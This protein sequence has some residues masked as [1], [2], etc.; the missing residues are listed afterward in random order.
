MTTLNATPVSDLVTVTVNGEEKKL[1]KGKN[2]L[3]ALLDDG[4]YIPHYCWHPSISVAGNC[5]LCLVEIEG[6]PR[7]NVSCNMNCSEGLKI[8]TDSPMVEDCRKGMMELL[9]VNHPLDCPVCDRGGECMLQRYSM[10]YG[11][12]TARTTDERRRF[13]KPQFDPLVDIERNRCIMC[14]RCVR[15]MDEVA[16]DHLLG[17]FGRGNRNY[18]GTFGNGPVAN[19]FS[20]NIIDIC[21]VGCL[22]S[23]PFRFQARAW[24]LQQVTSTCN[25]CSAG[26]P[27]TAWIRDG[28]LMRMTP[29]AAKYKGQWTIDE[30]TTKFICNEGRF[31]NYYANGE[32][33]LMKGL[34][35]ENGVQT[36]CEW[37]SGISHAAAALKNAATSGADKVAILTGAR[38]TNEEAYLLSRLAKSVLGTNQIDWRLDA[39]SAE[40][41]RAIGAALAS[42][43]GDIA[44][45]ETKAYGVTVVIQANLLDT[46]PVIGLKVKEA[47]R[48]KHTKLAVL[49]SRLDGWMSEQ[50]A[51]TA[52]VAPESLA[53]AVA[54][55]GG[56]GKASAE[57]EQIAS[58][59][60]GS[61]TGLIVLGM[62]GSGGANTSRIFAAVSELL[63]K[64]PEGWRFLPVIRGRNAKGAFAAGAQSDRLPSGS[65]TSDS[66]RNRM[67]EMWG[68]VAAAGED[69]PT[70]MDILERA[71]AGQIETLFL[72]RCDELVHHP[73]R[74]L[75]E[76]AL[77][78]TPNVI[79]V[80]LFPSWVTKHA[81]V[82][83]PGAAFFETEGSLTSADGTILAL[84]QAN[85]A[86]GDAQEDWRILATLM[87][88]IAG[89]KH[90]Y[91]K[92][93]DVLREVLTCWQSPRVFTINELRLDGPGVESP[94]RPQSVIRKKARPNFR[95]H[96]TERQAF[97]SASPKATKPAAG[98]LRLIYDIAVH[99]PDHL[100]TRSREFD[101]LRPEP[102]I[103]LHPDDAKR[104]KLGAGD[105]VRVSG[106]R[107]EKMKVRINESLVKGCAYGASNVLGLEIAEGDELPVIEIE[108]VGS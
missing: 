97:K 16:G 19:N 21:P 1:P 37:K 107:T 78:A 35:R 49:D 71:A 77:E 55:L 82:L 29:P 22:T 57:I 76:K 99:G 45:L 67:A 12:G 48:L 104:L 30:D 94:Q 79:V 61:P 33:R 47:A 74:A 92:L 83:L 24:E 80:D 87:E 40:A 36:E 73:R 6:Q 53:D 101:K 28:E 42:S 38:A 75:I 63:G 102:V 65:A 108:K 84:N 5:R 62:D 32:D 8:K 20:G 41:A 86:P 9:L 105:E 14:T 54:C 27:T 68:M 4:H 70:A 72:F 26:C 58:L 103:E 90:S 59:I 11:T 31:G 50:G 85:Q 89:Q 88:E 15:F 46:V 44:Q 93:D 52:L 23:K 7:P 3:K 95:L 91:A 18:I 13:E 51:A 69:A 98:S 56:K 64:L 10:D 66:A 96:F 81:S 2:L 100:S 25:L 106:C 34:V 39:T 17:V 60:A 43:D